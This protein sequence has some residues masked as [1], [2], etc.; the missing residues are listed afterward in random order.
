VGPACER[1][2]PEDSCRFIVIRTEL[3]ERI[4]LRLLRALAVKRGAA[5]EP[6]P[7]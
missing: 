4:G 1:H 5:F 6:L 2:Q 7:I 3:G